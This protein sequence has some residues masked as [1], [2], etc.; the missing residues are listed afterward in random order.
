MA[1]RRDEE[2]AGSPFRGDDQAIQRALEA[3][4]HAEREA[5]RRRLAPCGAF[6]G[7]YVVVGV[8]GALVTLLCIL[9]RMC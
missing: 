6:I 5:A 4:R 9:L 2:R 7:A 3:Q 1:T 8:T